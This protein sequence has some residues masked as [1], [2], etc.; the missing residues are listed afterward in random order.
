MVILDVLLLVRV[1]LLIQSIIIVLII[2]ISC[3]SSIISVCLLCYRDITLLLLLS[4]LS[5]LST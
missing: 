1:L 3:R 5:S 4:L 2:T